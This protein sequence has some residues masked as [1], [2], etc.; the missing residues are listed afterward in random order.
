MPYKV[1]KQKDKYCVQNTDTQEMKG[2]SDTQ[3]EAEAHM[4]AMYAAENKATGDPTSPDDWA[5]VP[6]KDHSSTWKLRIDD[7]QHL[8]QAIT[9]L[10]P[11]GYR[12]QKVEIPA[13]DK[14]SVIRKIRAAINKL[15]DEDQKKNLLERLSKVS[16]GSKMMTPLTQQETNYQAAGGAVGKACSNCRWYIPQDEDYDSAC[17]LVEDMP[18]PIVPNGLCDRWE[19]VPAMTMD[20]QPLPVAIVTEGN[21]SAEDSSGDS[22]GMPWAALFERLRRKRK[23]SF[24]GFKVLDNNRWVGWFTN[25]F[26]DREQEI[27]TE[28]AIDDFISSVKG[29]KAPYPELWFWHIKGTKH[30]QTD[31]L[32]RVGH[33]ALA[34]GTF[35]TT[36]FAQKL[37]AY[38]KTVD[39]YA[40]SHGFFYP[41][42]QK[43]KGIYH[44]FTTFEI[45][46]LRRSAAAND[47]TY[48]EVKKMQVPETVW[49]ELGT[50]VGVD[51]MN[52]IRQ[53]VEARE[54]AGE[55]SRDWK[56]LSIPPDED[57]DALK[58]QLGDVATG[59]KDITHQLSS[60]KAVPEQLSGVQALVNAL[61]QRVTET[62]KQLALFSDLAPRATRS[63]LTVADE[64]D[65]LDL[66]TAKEKAKAAGQ[67]SF[68]EQML[69]VTTL[70][71]K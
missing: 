12:G 27:F 28:K 15:S 33:F 29:G 22:S 43:R 2:C 8:A 39:D 42:S 55:E 31:G 49:N 69:S 47:L 70:G 34:T 36:P 59:V 40:M 30:G 63:P 11:G 16:S 61:S 13:A 51:E 50:A 14:P 65:K 9:A 54:K 4:K 62:E 32:W 45:S 44:A 48:W 56:G 37:K 25:N 7:E 66:E 41:R 53:A 6:D 60:L 67:K 23:K 57:M 3:A 68:V 19:A 64:Q 58:K 35:D 71:E 24:V 17:Y 46:P 26:R 18:A 21:A 1:V 20:M 10:S 52:A 5:Y 38:Y